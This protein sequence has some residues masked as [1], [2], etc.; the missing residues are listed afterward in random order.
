MICSKRRPVNWV[1]G[2]ALA[3]VGYCGVVFV[4]SASQAQYPGS[5]GD[6]SGSA[7]A[8]SSS[9]GYGSGNGSSSSSANSSAKSSEGPISDSPTDA[10]TTESGSYDGAN[11][12]DGHEGYR[13]T[14]VATL[15]AN[16]AQRKRALIR[17]FRLEFAK[18]LIIETA[19]KR[20]L[21][22]L[23]A[24]AHLDQFSKEINAG[25]GQ[26]A[27]V[28]SLSRDLG[29][30]RDALNDRIDIV[31]ASY[32]GDTSLHGFVSKTGSGGETASALRTEV[33]KLRLKHELLAFG[34]YSLQAMGYFA[35]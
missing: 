4:S 25:L 18:T 3:L 1:C 9:A 32:G 31:I 29:L 15:P 22:A 11:G 7:H 2:A 26:Q 13:T 34:E 35:K 23:Y 19:T 14:T 17:Q 8:A 24:N 20:P 33:Q 30:I 5:A 10:F 6:L 12:P 21:H 27:N 16:R 28:N